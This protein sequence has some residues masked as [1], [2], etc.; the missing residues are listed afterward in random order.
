M[1]E[2]AEEYYRGARDEAKE[3]EAKIDAL[4]ASI[5]ELKRKKVVGKWDAIDQ[6]Y[7]G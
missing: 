5:F 6:G 3:S 4:Q 1:S 7:T 2:K